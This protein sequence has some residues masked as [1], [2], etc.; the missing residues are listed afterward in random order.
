MQHTVRDIRAKR[1]SRA[2]S[3]RQKSTEERRRAPGQARVV[4]LSGYQVME[5]ANQ[6]QDQAAARRPL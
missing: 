1:V 6:Q 4:S 3:G 5:V 2:R